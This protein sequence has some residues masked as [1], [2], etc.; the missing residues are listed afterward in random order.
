MSQPRQACLYCGKWVKRNRSYCR[1]GKAVLR[2]V[3][4]GRFRTESARAVDEGCVTYAAV[5]TDTRRP[6]RIRVQRPSA[7]PGDV[8]DLVRELH[9][10]RDNGGRGPFPR[11]FVSGRLAGSEL[12]YVVCELVEGRTLRET[13]KGDPPARVVET[14]LSCAMAVAELND[15]GW[16]HCALSL[17]SF[18]IGESG[19]VSLVDLRGITR[20]GD[21]GRGS[22][23]P[24]YKA[25]EQYT[26]GEQVDCMTDVFAMGACLYELLTGELPYP[27]NPAKGLAKPGFRPKLPSSLNPNVTPLLDT[28]VMRALERSPERRHAN[29]RAMCA[30]LADVFARRTE[31]D[32]LGIGFATWN[33]RLWDS[34]RTAMGLFKRALAVALCPVLSVLR[35]LVGWFTFLPSGAK[36]ALVAVMLI[37]LGLTSIGVW[38]ATGEATCQVLSWP[39]SDVYINGAYVGEAPSP[40]RILLG[41]GR[42]RVRFIGRRDQDME[43]VFWCWPGARYLVSADLQ[44]RAFAVQRRAK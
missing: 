7:L 37:V 34:T 39:V 42:N 8:K 29:V 25:P 1:C 35:L 36:R 20:A 9:F 2:N 21:A 16:V 5:D 27:R 40:T 24:G 18:V 41:A 31:V 38:M 44:Q 43:F 28:V 10:L 19:R 22:G 30:E 3:A 15:L 17:D 6:V 14:W 32:E 13:T 11:F 26:I 33:E 4:G 12:A 23:I